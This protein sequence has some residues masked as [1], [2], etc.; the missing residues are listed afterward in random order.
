LE[1]EFLHKL[2]LKKIEMQKFPKVSTTFLS[3]TVGVFLTVQ[4]RRFPNHCFL[5]LSNSSSSS[6]QKASGI[7]LSIEHLAHS[8]VVPKQR[9]IIAALDA[10]MRRILFTKSFFCV[11]HLHLLFRQQVIIL[12]N[13]FFDLSGW[14]DIYTA[15]TSDKM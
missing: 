2:L 5:M 15:E 8:A 4:M 11:I 12:N 6:L 14:V 1:L 3:K 7:T 10:R 9:I 13:P